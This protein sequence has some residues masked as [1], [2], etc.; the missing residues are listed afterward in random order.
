[1]KLVYVNELGL[2]YKGERTYEFIFNDT[3]KGVHGNDWDLSP[4]SG[5]PTPPE[6]QFI[7][8][9]GVL[10]DTELKLELVQNSDYFSVLDAVDEVIALGWESLDEGDVEDA[11]RLV[12]K[13]GEA[14]EAVIA[15]LTARKLKLKTTD[16]K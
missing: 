11:K 5:R 10:C 13:Y 6:L 7:K 3:L 14:I 15:K 16:I 9:V 4:A 8:V 2:D 12:F 1:M